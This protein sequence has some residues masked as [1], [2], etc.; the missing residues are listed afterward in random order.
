L[1]S[2]SRLRLI[3]IYSLADSK[4]RVAEAVIETPV[5]VEGKPQSGDANSEGRSI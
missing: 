4:L 5:S 2:I 3:F 1:L